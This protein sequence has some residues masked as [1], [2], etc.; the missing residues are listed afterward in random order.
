MIL[1]K[2]I[3]A[4]QNINCGSPKVIMGVCEVYKCWALV[5]AGM[6]IR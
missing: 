1:K 5:S 4:T 3:S 2:K 6:M